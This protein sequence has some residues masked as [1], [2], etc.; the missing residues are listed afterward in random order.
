MEQVPQKGWAV[1]APWSPRLGV[2]LLVSALDSRVLAPPPLPE[3][4][5]PGDPAPPST[6]FGRIDPWPVW[7]LSMSW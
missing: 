7:W 5:V 6:G 3:S 4:S 1:Y 2:G